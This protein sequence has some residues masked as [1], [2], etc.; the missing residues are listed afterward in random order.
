MLLLKLED[1]ELIELP[2]LGKT[3]LVHYPLDDM[4]IVV[5]MF[6]KAVCDVLVYGSD[7]RIRARWGPLTPRGRTQAQRAE[8]PKR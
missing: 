1:G 3:L 5:V 2:S 6:L 4:T 7:N 8:F